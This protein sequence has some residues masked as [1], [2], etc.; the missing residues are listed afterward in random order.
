MASIK[1]VLISGA[2]IAGPA[3]AYW[4]RRYGFEPTVV[5]RAPAPRDGGQAI[6]VRGSAREVAARMGILDEVRRAHTGVRG[7]AFVDAAGHRTASM[8]ADLLGDSGGPIAELEI[9]RG[10][11]VRI[12]H[13]TTRDVEYRFDDTITAMTS[14]DAGVD[15]AFA[16]GPSRRF[17]LVVGADGLHSTVRALAFGPEADFT[18]DL[19]CY[20]AVF[21]T[22][23]HPDLQ[24]FQLMHTIPAA[25]GRLGRTAAVS[26]A[27]GRTGTAMF[28]FAAPPLAH[29][30]RD[31]ASQK[32]LLAQAF[33]GDGW[34]IP[35]LLAAM[36]DA[37]DFY[38]DRVSQIRMRAWSKGRVVLVGDAAHCAS[39]LAGNGSSMALVGAYVLA[40]ELAAAPGDHQRAVDGYDRT[41]RD[42]V[43]RCQAFATDGVGSLMPSSRLH[44]TLRDMSIRML[45]Y[46]PWRGLFFRGLEKTA[47][48]VAIRD[49]GG[50][51]VE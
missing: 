22:T 36:P 9:L 20:V 11:L 25:N 6:D 28:F 19:G 7:M 49:Y 50:A 29:D 44:V 17:D 34:D 42:Y 32:R 13:A 4:L 45:P 37:P 39:P 27:L 14:T 40:G 41:M 46:L 47:R 15:V 35:R 51:M 33:E 16:R 31:V 30:R 38:F 21:T 23:T 8:G 3:L 2:S 24:G 48:A 12:L 26:P 43:T 1:T 5:E 10:D 18:H